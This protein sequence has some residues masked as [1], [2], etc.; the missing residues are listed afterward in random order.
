MAI[1]IYIYI[2]SSKVLNPVQLV[3]EKPISTA[4]K[5]LLYLNVSI[6]RA[7][8]ALPTLFDDVQRDYHI[9]SVGTG[10]LTLIE[11]TICKFLFGSYTELHFKWFLCIPLVLHT[12]LSLIYSKDI[13]LM[14]LN[15]NAYYNKNLFNPFYILLVIGVFGF[16]I[17]FNSLIGK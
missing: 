17:L 1:V 13:R 5:I 3:P 12:S 15:Y 16:L 11:Y 8:G 9:S 4:E 2:S 14:A 6:Y 10:I 7:V